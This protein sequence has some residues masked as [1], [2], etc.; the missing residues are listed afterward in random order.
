MPEIDIRPFKENTSNADILNAIRKNAS[1]S[2]K[3][4]IPEATKANIQETLKNL[5]DYKPHWNEFSDALL[6]RIGLMVI[7][8]TMWTNPL[9]KFKRGMLT[10]GE[11]IEEVNFGLIKARVYNVDRLNLE[12]D[13]FGHYPPE[14]QSSFHRI[15]RQ[16]Y[17]PITVNEK[18]L[19]R[20]FL[21]SS[22]LQSF[23]SNTMAVPTNSDQVDEFEVTC[24]LFGE[25]YKNDG[26]FKIQVGDLS[27]AGS[28]SADA[29][30]FLRRVREMAA[31]LSFVS[32]LYNASGMPMAVNP[33][34]LEL[35][36][37]PQALAA[38][39]VE[40]LAGAFNV[41]KMAM[42]GRINV[43]P[44]EKFRIPGVQ[45][46]LTTREF[47]VIA[48][49]NIQTASQWNPVSLSTNL[50]LHHWE[51]ISASRFTP[52]ILFTTEAGTAVNLDDEPVTGI[53]AI[54]LFDE[55][56]V[57]VTEVLR[58]EKYQLVASAIS[59]SI[60]NTDVRVDIVGNTTER[61]YLTQSGVLY[62]APTEEATTLRV[63]VYSVD[64]NSST[65]TA[66]LNLTVVG[67]LLE[68][69]PNP[70]VSLDDDTDGLYEVTPKVLVMD[71]E[72]DTVTIPTVKGVLYKKEGVDVA[73]GSDHVIV[74]GPINFTAV[75]R[76]GS[77]LAAGAPAA[78]SFTV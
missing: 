32:S 16:E 61:T 37:T 71:G 7:K 31:E 17:Y 19:E 25:Y 65:Q 14:V 9:A 63:D 52:A 41:D 23:V 53:S 48:D 73:N 46:I 8:N 38:I 59:A 75:A 22:G 18:L 10:F 57:S 24:S 40:A 20:A 76:A 42:M 74:G 35:F 39:D 26:F 62:I 44:K 29:K 50:F 33:D 28:D 11:S 67:A 64:T 5:T 34:D 56:E 43:I 13:V 47:F 78:W 30:F 4:R 58:G 70:S 55:N 72:T 77:E 1:P 36:I 21:E 51:I 68:L 45:A 27:S 6:N 69:W 49:T 15:N 2:Y 3:N 60:D 54:T 12:R 66:S